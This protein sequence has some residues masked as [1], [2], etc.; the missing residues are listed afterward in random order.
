[1]ILIHTTKYGD[2]GIILHG[3]TAEGGKESFLL[4]GLGK[5]KEVS[6]SILHPLSI[7]EIETSHSPK[8]TLKNIKELS[9]AH[10]L[11]SLR[12]NIYKNS[13]AIFLSEVLYR[14]LRESSGDVELYEFLEKSILDLNREEENFS[15]F[16]LYFLSQYISKLGFRPREFTFDDYNPFSSKEVSLLN[17][18]LSLPFA[19]AM[20][21]PL[22]GEERY[23]FAK[24]LLNYLEYH[25][26]FKFEIKSLV[27]LHQLCH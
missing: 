10:R 11:N 5:R 7:L 23:L 9:S 2:S 22:K 15:N 1:M 27:I 26:G 25:L 13:I 20:L 19:E 21:I 8:S 4:R 3:Y 17:S 24:S 18:L 14:T 12:S 6:S 16:H